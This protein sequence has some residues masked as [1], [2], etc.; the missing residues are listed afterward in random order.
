MPL[1]EQNQRPAQISV[2]PRLEQ[3]K[4]LRVLQ[5]DPEHQRTQPGDYFEL[6]DDRPRRS[7]PAHL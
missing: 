2:R 3:I 1:R 5:R 7:D 4:D 6:P